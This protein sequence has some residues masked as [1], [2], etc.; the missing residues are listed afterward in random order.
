MEKGGY[1]YMLTNKNNSTIYIGVTG[2]ME[3]RILEHKSKKYPNSFSARYH[4]HKLV[5]MEFFESI[6][7]AILREKQLKGDSR[8]TKEALI[9]LIRNGMI[10]QSVLMNL[11]NRMQGNSGSI[12]QIASPH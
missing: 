10:Y 11:L 2:D 6:D 3:A 12:W 9:K 5:Y 8:K 4:L 7:E 1:I